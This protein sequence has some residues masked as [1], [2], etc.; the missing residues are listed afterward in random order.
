MSADDLA[1]EK[2]RFAVAKQEIRSFV[3]ACHQATSYQIGELEKGSVYLMV[4]Y[5]LIAGALSPGMLSQDTGLRS[6][7]SDIDRIGA[8][9][10]RLYSVFHRIS[11]FKIVV[12]FPTAVEFGISMLRTAGSMRRY[13]EILDKG[14]AIADKIVEA[15]MTDDRLWHRNELPVGLKNL[16]MTTISV[17][18][19]TDAL[20]QFSSFV[21]SNYISGVGDVLSESFYYTHKGEI[22]SKKNEISSFLDKYRRRHGRP[23]ENFR[24]SNKIDATNMSAGFSL[25]HVNPHKTLSFIGPAPTLIAAAG[26]ADGFSDF[27]AL[28][29]KMTV[30]T[31]LQIYLRALEVAAKELNVPLEEASVEL[32]ADRIRQKAWQEINKLKQDVELMWKEIR[33]FDKFSQLRKKENDR[34]TFLYENVL[35]EFCGTQP[36]EATIKKA[37]TIFSSTEK[38]A[39]RFDATGAA[40]ESAA[41][42]IFTIK[43]IITSEQLLNDIGWATDEEIERL[44]ERLRVFNQAPKP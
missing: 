24:L 36:G 29:K 16:F 11:D 15:I 26:Y 17:A 30:P 28:T 8:D 35:P 14:T 4:D 6:Y 1:S 5:A 12:T 40:M 7:D 21:S 18:A 33:E 44:N 34:L 9:I 42:Q 2:A 20:K 3:I 39:R 25:G 23:T 22:M 27:V 43:P 10:F 41:K 13:A 37:K 31:M 38:F 19:G 32:K